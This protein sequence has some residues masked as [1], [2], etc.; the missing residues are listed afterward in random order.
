MKD[1][2]LQKKKQKK[3]QLVNGWLRLYIL[4]GRDK[5]SCQRGE[6]MLATAKVSTI[7]YCLE[8]S[9]FS[10]AHLFVSSTGPLE[11]YTNGRWESLRMQVESG[12]A[13]GAQVSPFL[14]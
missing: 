9:V 13:G 10:L 14:G 12:Q 5:K 2:C 3:Q 1:K 6:R 11:T 7:E 8:L 4:Q